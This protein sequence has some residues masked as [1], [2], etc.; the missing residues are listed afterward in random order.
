MHKKGLKALA[1]GGG[2]QRTQ[3]CLLEGCIDEMIGSGSDGNN[4]ELPRVYILKT[5]L[6]V[7][8]DRAP[9]E[10]MHQSLSNGILQECCKASLLK[11]DASA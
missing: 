7:S 4:T 8:E 5:G 2:K 11:F 6:D 10:R 1:V 9:V 3:R